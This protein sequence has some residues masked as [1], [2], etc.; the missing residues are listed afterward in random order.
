MT[1]EAVC[2]VYVMQVSRNA[3][4]SYKYL[5]S[6]MLTSFQKVTTDSRGHVQNPSDPRLL[7]V[8]RVNVFSCSE[9]NFTV[10]PPPAFLPRREFVEFPFFSPATRHAQPDLGSAGDVQRMHESA[11]AG[12]VLKKKQGCFAGRD[13]DGMWRASPGRRGH[14]IISQPHPA[15]TTPSGR[16]TQK[17]GRPQT[18]QPGR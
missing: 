6:D 16:A 9:H 8:T 3:K 14:A 18:P 11:A 13:E 15:R 1:N 5:T 12:Y 17:Q 2:R 10:C 4:A 7:R